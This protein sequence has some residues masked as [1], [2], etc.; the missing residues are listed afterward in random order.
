MP[1]SGA[2]LTI[3][4]GQNV[5]QADG[6]ITFQPLSGPGR[7]IGAGDTGTG[8]GD[9]GSGAGGFAG[10]GFTIT[11][12]AAARDS[13][14]VEVFW[15]VLAGNKLVW[16]C[17]QEVMF[18]AWVNWQPIFFNQVYGLGPTFYVDLVEYRNLPKPT[19]F[20]NALSFVNFFDVTNSNY[21]AQV[22]PYD[23]GRTLKAKVQFPIHAEFFS[24]LNTLL[25][26][27]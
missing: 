12:P 3:T 23:S 5:A 22:N 27:L 1:G 6:T 14:D 18:E 25:N 10:D 19:A 26:L 20:R 15:P 16:Q 4:V 11:I 9:T 2:K 7:N 24:D 17:D 8:A 13:G 21:I